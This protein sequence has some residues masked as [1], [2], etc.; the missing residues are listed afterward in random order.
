MNKMK[1][2]WIWICILL[3]ATLAA[4]GAPGGSSSREGCNDEEKVCIKL[5]VAEP[6]TTGQPVEVTITVTSE[7][8]IP[9]LEL[10]LGYFALG[11]KIVID[12]E[13]GLPSQKDDKIRWTAS[14][15]ANRPLVVKR[16]VRFPRGEGEYDV[17]D[18]IASAQ[19]R[20]VKVIRSS[21]RVHLTSQGG[22]AY[23]SG[24]PIPITPGPEPTMALR[25]NQVKK[26]CV[27]LSVAEPITPGQPASVTI[28]VTSEKDIP[29]LG[30]SLN[31]HSSGGKVSIDEEPGMP[32][33]KDGLVSWTVDVQANRALTFR[34]TMRFSGVEG[35][36]DLIFLDALINTGGTVIHD[37]L[38]IYLTQDGGDVYYEGTPLPV[39]LEPLPTNTP[40]P[41]QDIYP[42]PSFNSTSTPMQLS[43]PNP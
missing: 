3:L 29:K 6:I 41:T 36:Y 22:K 20:G 31:S 16:K 2:A 30:I 33:P 24:T 7:K 12:E 37:P 5:T 23:Y 11:K 42:N 21:V 1:L 43:Y 40:R 14:I 8:D 34:R 26:A 19:L 39:P 4:C 18:L 35:E 28:T 13:P 27:K 17:I 9:N 38:I 10:G 25:C 32:N 15:Q